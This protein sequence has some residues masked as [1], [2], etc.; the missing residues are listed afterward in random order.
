MGS[1]GFVAVDLDL[2]MDSNRK[3]SAQDVTCPLC[4]LPHREPFSGD[5]KHA[6]CKS[7]WAVYLTKNLPALEQVK[8]PTCGTAVKLRELKPDQT[9]QRR[10]QK[11]KNAR[12]KNCS[13]RGSYSDYIE[14]HE[15]V[16]GKVVRIQCK[17]FGCGK[18]L[19]K[20]RALELHR[21]DD[22]CPMILLMKTR[23]T[24]AEILHLSMRET[25]EWTCGLVLRSEKAEVRLYVERLVLVFSVLDPAM[26]TA[27]ENDEYGATA[28]IT[29][30]MCDRD[31]SASRAGSRW[32]DN[33][34]QKK[35]SDEDISGNN[36]HRNEPDDHRWISLNHENSMVGSAA[37]NG[38]YTDI[39]PTTE[40]LRIP[41]HRRTSG[42]GQDNDTHLD[43]LTLKQEV[44]KLTQEVDNCNKCYD[45][46]QELPR[47]VAAIHDQNN[48]V[49]GVMAAL[50]HPNDL[51]SQEKHEKLSKGIDKMKQEI[52]SL[53]QSMQKLERKMLELECSYSGVF[54]W[55][56]DNYSQRKREAATT[57]KKSIY[58]PPFFTNQYGY[59]L[60]GRVFLMG[61]G[62]GK[63]T[64][65]SLFLTI[66]RGPHDAVLPWPFNQKIIFQ[67]VNQA[68][69]I[70][71]SI[72]E[73]FR[74]DPT[75]SSFKRPT[76]DRNIGAGCPLFAKIQLVEDLNQGYL[77][78]D[79]LYLKIISQTSDVLPELK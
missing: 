69:P 55:K 42:H 21:A 50:Q 68:D 27:L 60:C 62:V 20:N 79:T 11:F 39:S 33:F 4:R 70:N 12:C 40:A 49:E 65:I 37:L 17:V 14:N 45:D 13:W 73:S 19:P 48:V 29:E 38:T 15:R 36:A 57:N 76:S 43:L 44:S 72:V 26:P 46:L 52:D 1:S 8:C 63:G 34:S 18:W 10:L 31:V 51:G 24:Q 6:C 56:I 71:K 58:S 67:L 59:K 3:T 32:T 53:I 64:H 5:C 66:M 28:Q 77:K 41:F 78:D 54:L 23:L 35:L 7:C 30:D 16:C 9:A 74:P 2:E 25:W 47:A 75:S 61:D 22:W